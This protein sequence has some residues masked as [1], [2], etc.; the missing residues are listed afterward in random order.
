MNQIEIR[1]EMRPLL[2]GMYHSIP[3]EVCKIHMGSGGQSLHPKHSA[4]LTLCFGQD[5]RKRWEE[6]PL[7]QLNPLAVA[8]RMGLPPSHQKAPSGTCARKSRLFARLLI[9]RTSQLLKGP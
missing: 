7:L 2:S 4:R 9:Y 3:L 1:E 8:Q 5:R 6:L